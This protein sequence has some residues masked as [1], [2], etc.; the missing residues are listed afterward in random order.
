VDLRFSKVLASELK[1]PSAG[2]EILFFYTSIPAWSP[3]TSTH[4]LL[5]FPGGEVAGAPHIPAGDRAP[6]APFFRTLFHLG[7][8]GE[9]GGSDF[10]GWFEL[11]EGE[12]EAFADAVVGDRQDI[13][14]A[15]AEDEEHLDGPAADAADLGQVLDDGFVGHAA[16]AG[17]GGDGAVD[18]LG[19]E[20]ADGE[21]FVV[22]EAGGAELLVWRV[23]EV[24]GRRMFAESGDGVEAGEEFGMDGRGRL[25]VEL[26]VDDGFEQRLKGRLGAG[27]FEGEW[28][29]SGDEFAEFGVASGELL[30]RQGGVVSGGE[31]AKFRAGHDEEKGK[32][33]IFGYGKLG[34]FGLVYEMNAR[35]FCGSAVWVHDR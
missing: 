24:L 28:A 32:S 33:P 22:G 25:A 27:E 7:G 34:P 15:E 26:L 4:S 14:T 10:V 12:G 6:G 5:L 23:E 21:R 31:R 11:A 8:F 20:V 19:G 3:G 16:D 2:L 18:G 1:R 9:V 13:G 30:D 35:L 29:G 17:E